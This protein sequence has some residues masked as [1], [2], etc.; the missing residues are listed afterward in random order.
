[1]CDERGFEFGFGDSVP[2]VCAS[3]YVRTNV[4]YMCKHNEIGN[5]YSRMY[6]HAHALWK[7]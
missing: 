3:M 2:E 4:V 6:T 5:M 7:L 1:M